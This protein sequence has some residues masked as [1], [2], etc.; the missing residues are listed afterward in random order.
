MKVDRAHFRSPSEFV[1]ELT[2]LSRRHRSADLFRDFFEASYCALAKRTA[3]RAD[4]AEALEKRYMA[5]VDKYGDA[6]SEVMTGMSHLLGRLMMTILDDFPPAEI[7]PTPDRT[8]SIPHWLPV[9]D[10]LGQAYMESGMNDVRRD[11]QM[12][13]PSAV[14]SAMGAMSI[15]KESIDTI[16]ADGRLVTVL[17]CTCGSGILIIAFAAQLRE[18]GY[19]LERTLYATL[20]DVDQLCMQMA[21]LQMETLGIPAVVVHG[22]SL[23]LEEYEQA[24]T[25]AAIRQLIARDGK[26]A[27]QST[28]PSAGAAEPEDAPLE[29]AAADRKP[30]TVAEPPACADCEVL[31]DQPVGVDAPLAKASPADRSSEPTIQV[32]LFDDTRAA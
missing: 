21:F 15:D 12:F 23:T 22:N 10:F 20:V 16:L 7:N 24:L 13:T 18:L 26:P 2:S 27:Q 31:P 19:D 3:L 32:D 14:A 28:T 5:V 29:E 11:K 6:K 1:R 8:A 4:H 9:S 30:L 17:D 25:S